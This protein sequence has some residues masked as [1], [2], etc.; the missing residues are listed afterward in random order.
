M[1]VKFS[2]LTVK[3]LTGVQL[4]SCISAP[5]FMLSTFSCS[6]AGSKQLTPALHHGE[7][8]LEVE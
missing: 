2:D 4:F 7:V 3:V 1:C 6:V 5:A 8:L